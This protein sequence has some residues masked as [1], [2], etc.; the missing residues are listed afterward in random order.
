M[1]TLICLIQ[2]TQRKKKAR[3]IFLNHIFIDILT[4]LQFVLTLKVLDYSLLIASLSHMLEMLIN[5]VKNKDMKKVSVI[6]Q[7]ISNVTIFIRLIWFCLKALGY[8]REFK[9]TAD[10]LTVY[11]VA[12]FSQNFKKTSHPVSAGLILT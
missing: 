1:L 3:C 7:S 4:S 9:S 10:M 6:C 12:T 2:N 5:C 8:F 11:P